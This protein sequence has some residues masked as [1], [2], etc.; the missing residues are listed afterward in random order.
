MPIISSALGFIRHHKWA[1]AI[2][3]VIL[4]PIIALVVFALKPK[5]PTYVTQPAVR[6]DITQTVEAVGTVI[7][8][9]NLNLQFPSTGIV[10]SV[11]VKEG[12]RVSAGEVLAQLT[13]G[14][15]AA[16]VQSA[17]GQVQA[18]QAN[19]DALLQGSRPEDVAV[20]QADVQNKQ[21]SLEA[22]QKSLVA[23]QTE[24]DSNLAGYVANVPGVMQQ[25]LTTAD[26]ALTTIENIF[27]NNNVSDAVIASGR[28]DVELLKQK[29]Q[30]DQA[31]I[32]KLMTTPNPTE[33]DASI[34]L[35]AQTRA[36]VQS[37]SIDA[38]KSFQIMD[39][40]PATGSFS[41]T[42]RTTYEASISTQRSSL[43][44]SLSSL[45]TTSKTMTDAQASYAKQITQDQADIATYQSALQI[46]QAQLML[47]QAPPRQ[48]DIDSAEAQLQQAKGSLAA[49]AANYQN[50]VLTAPIDGVITKVTVKAGEALPTGVA[51]SM[52]GNSP[53]RIEMYV[54]EVDIPKVQLT[55]TG[56]VELDAFR[57]THFGLHVTQIDSSPTNKDGVDKYRVRLDFTYPHDDILKVGMTGDAEIDTGTRK[58]VVNIP[59]RAVLQSATG[60]KTVRILQK[61][62]TIAVKTV[63][64]GLEGTD[65][66]VEIVS[67]VQEGDSVVVLVK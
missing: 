59:L 60:E 7:S 52:L 67:G 45:D 58:N 14:N 64:T 53:Y 50:T 6:G 44:S 54:S 36:A 20:T 55:Q 1:T 11:Y 4:L 66:N 24:A 9:R 47:K 31:T 19:L 49:A 39:A 27:T 33:F 29:T 41:E 12:D 38:D 34:Q 65:G 40:L 30:A 26:I 3:V 25:Q 15:L 51:I 18:A 57:G 8:D 22:A 62:G 61:D 42:N 16:N 10:S 17:R 23:T 46:A 21:A 2:T 5:K 13:A 37:A 48:T 32:K 56:S 63:T 35:L 43:Q 28:T